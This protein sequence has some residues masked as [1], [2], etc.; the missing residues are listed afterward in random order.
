MIR[1]SFIPFRI[2][3]IQSHTSFY[4]NLVTENNHFTLRGSTFLSF[5][6]FH[7]TYAANWRNCGNVAADI[8]ARD[9]NLDEILTTRYCGYNEETLTVSEDFGGEEIY[10]HMLLDDQWEREYDIWNI[11]LLN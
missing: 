11:D 2:I 4:R 1:L 6:E 7:T 10:Y 3:P 9:S 5:G 8:T